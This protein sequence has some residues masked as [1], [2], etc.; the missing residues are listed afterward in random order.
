M[1]KLYILSIFTRKNP[2]KMSL[3]L[4]KRKKFLVLLQYLWIYPQNILDISGY[5]Q[6]YIYIVDIYG[7]ILR[8][9]RKAY[10]F[11]TLSMSKL[12][13]MDNIVEMSTISWTF[14]SLL[15]ISSKGIIFQALKKNKQS[16]LINNQKK[17]LFKQELDKNLTRNLLSLLIPFS[18]SEKS[19]YESMTMGVEKS[20]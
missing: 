13:N 12:Q 16:L 20:L 14:S 17:K 10:L 6:I 7:H 4:S 2:K 18:F 9:P 11:P 3:F 15:V 19:I 8:T 1:Y 5:S